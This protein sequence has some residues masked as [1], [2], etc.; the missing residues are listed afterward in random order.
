MAKK[1]ANIKVIIVEP[2]KPARVETIANELKTLQG[3]V[4]GYI[5]CIKTEDFDIIVNEEGKLHEL[6]PNFH[7][8]NGQDYVAGTAVFAAV[9]H[10]IGEFKSLNDKLIAFILEVFEER[11]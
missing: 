4:G 6:E 8:Y 9:N 7:I 2:N 3:L 11:A 1:E 10:K 5:E